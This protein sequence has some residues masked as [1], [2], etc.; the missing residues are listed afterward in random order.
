MRKE[1]TPSFSCSEQ[2]LWSP[3]PSPAAQQ[4]LVVS[5]KAA[6]AG[7]GLWADEPLMESHSDSHLLATSDLISVYAIQF[8]KFN[9]QSTKLEDSL[10]FLL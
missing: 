9:I 5:T 2:S 7:D 3:T 1:E 4:V 10:K 8:N 6:G